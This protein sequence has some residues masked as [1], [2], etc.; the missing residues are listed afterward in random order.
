MKHQTTTT[1]PTTKPNPTQNPFAVGQAA[2][3]SGHTIKSCPYQYGSIAWTRWL[4]GWNW[5]TSKTRKVAA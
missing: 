2:G 5:A 4:S 1:K 3:Q